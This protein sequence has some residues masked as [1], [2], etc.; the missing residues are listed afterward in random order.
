[1]RKLTAELSLPLV[2]MAYKFVVVGLR[3]KAPNGSRVVAL[4]LFFLSLTSLSKSRVISTRL[5]LIQDE[6]QMLFMAEASYYHTKCTLTPSLLFS[7]TVG[8]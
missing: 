4:L 7:R 1:M 5:A 2:Y 3:G 8:L 6:I